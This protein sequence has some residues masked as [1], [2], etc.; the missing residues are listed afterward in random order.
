MRWVVIGIAALLAVGAGYAVG[1]DFL[2]YL[3]LRKM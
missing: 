2:R 1:P 3:R